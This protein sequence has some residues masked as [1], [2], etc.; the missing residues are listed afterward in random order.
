MS[1]N[2]DYFEKVR[3]TAYGYLK[4]LRCGDPRFNRSVRIT[5]FDGVEVLDNAFLVVHRGPEN[6][7]ACI[8]VFSEH[9]GVRVYPRNGLRDWAQYERIGDEDAPF[10]VES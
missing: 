8:I 9:Y 5:H 3:R 10:D 4:T 7:P 6:S 1:K 2:I